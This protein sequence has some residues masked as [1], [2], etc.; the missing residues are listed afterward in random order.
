MVFGAAW[1][2]LGN[3]TDAEDV[4]QEVF[5]E[6]YLKWRDLATFVGRICCGG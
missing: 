5:L 4:A 6:A 1:R 3:A 2:I